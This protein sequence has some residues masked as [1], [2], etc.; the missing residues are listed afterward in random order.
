[1]KQTSSGVRAKKNLG[2]HFLKDP[3]IAERIVGF[4]GDSKAYTDILEIG[5]GMGIL[6][7]FLFGRKHRTR[8][9]DL[10]E[11][12]ITYLNNRFPLRQDVSCRFLQMDFDQFS[13]SIC[14][15]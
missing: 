15:H 13:R 4:L 3:A 2:Q 9:V 10:D 14:Y 5:P 11:E 1:M 6:T 8:I 12:S 7:D